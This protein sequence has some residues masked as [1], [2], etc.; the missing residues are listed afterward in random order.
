M[1]TY[2][3]HTADGKAILHRDGN[4]VVLHFGGFHPFSSHQIDEHGC[5]FWGHYFK[6]V[7]EAIED[8]RKRARTF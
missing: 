1:E 7:E 3:E 8:C 6:T 2:K 5:T 4:Y